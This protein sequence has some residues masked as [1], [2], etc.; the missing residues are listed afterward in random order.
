MRPA[1]MASGRLLRSY[2]GVAELIGR[3]I[4]A[5]LASSQ[6]RVTGSVTMLL[7]PASAF[8]EGV[9]SPWSLMKASKGVYGESAGEWTA[10]DAQGYSKMLALPGVFW[11]R[12]GG[13][14]KP[15]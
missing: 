4:E 3:D 10:A 5:L 8:V 2:A 14:Q 13:G 1:L 7:R 12:A 11:M 15:Q 9:E 6:A